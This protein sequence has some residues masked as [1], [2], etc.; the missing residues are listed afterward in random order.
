MSSVRFDNGKRAVTLRGRER[1]WM[2][3][4]CNGLAF[5]A[6]SPS[7]FHSSPC[8]TRAIVPPDHYLHRS[9]RYEDDFHVWLNVSSHNMRHPVTGAMLDGFAV[10]L[11]TAMRLGSDEVRLLAR[12]HGQ[13][14]IHAFV[15]PDG[16]SFVATLIERG[17]KIGLYRPAMGWEDVRT[18][19]LESASQDRAVVTSYSVTDTFPGRNP[20]TDEPND[21]DAALA[22]L[23][24]KM[25][26]GEDL[27]TYHF[28]DG[29]TAM[30][31]RAAFDAA[32]ALTTTPS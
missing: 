13:C 8:W 32:R 27:A 23:D 21:W 14:E 16:A 25:A 30:S 20:E 6:F 29:E 1:Y 24:P 15:R 10:V 19:L 18:L 7:D 9:Q 5:T 12:L 28:G 17:L 31:L 2:A 26:I 4:V 3:H 11:N 22:A